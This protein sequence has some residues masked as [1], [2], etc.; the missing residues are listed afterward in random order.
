M[1]TVRP[2]AVLFL[3]SSSELSK[4]VHRSRVY[5][6][7]WKM[8]EGLPAFSVMDTGISLEEGHN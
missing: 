2:A 4:L 5:L 3:I 7:S 1:D 6:K 8:V